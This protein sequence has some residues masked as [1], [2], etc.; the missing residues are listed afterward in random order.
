MYVRISMSQIARW[1]EW[2]PNRVI[3]IHAWLKTSLSVHNRGNINK[4]YIH[5][6]DMTPNHSCAIWSRDS[7][8]SRVTRNVVRPFSWR[9]VSKARM[10]EKLWRKSRPH[11][12]PNLD[13][14]TTFTMT[15]S[16]TFDLDVDRLKHQNTTTV[17]C[18][19]CSLLHTGW[20]QSC[21]WNRTG[22]KLALALF[23][24]FQEIGPD[25]A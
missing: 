5:G 6:G 17:A 23:Q 2:C 20:Y 16:L 9:Y 4:P 18:D 15:L 25:F 8:L 13:I 21:D 7:T 12:W 11:I 1:S 19:A 24:K 14:G 3:Q 10:G 22:M